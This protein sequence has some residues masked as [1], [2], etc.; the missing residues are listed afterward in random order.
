[1]QIQ[2]LTFIDSVLFLPMPLRKLHEAFGISVTKS[3]YPQFFNTQANLNYVGP[4]PKMSQF[5]ADEMGECKRKEFLAWYDMQKDKVFDN[6]HV[7]E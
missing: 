5:G 1:M 7:F 6:R 3:W 2:H 4:I